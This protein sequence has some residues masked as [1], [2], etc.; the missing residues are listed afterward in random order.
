MWVYI[1]LDISATMTGYLSLRGGAKHSTKVLPLWWVRVWICGTHLKEESL[2]HY[3]LLN[4]IWPTLPQLPLLTYLWSS[5][6]C[7]TLPSQGYP[8]SIKKFP[9]LDYHD[10]LLDSIIVEFKIAMTI[11]FGW[12]FPCIF[13]MVLGIVLSLSCFSQLKSLRQRVGRR[14]FSGA[15]PRTCSRYYLFSISAGSQHYIDFTLSP[16]ASFA[17]VHYLPVLQ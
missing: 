10:I 8:V 12:Y 5:L 11:F 1:P 16:L 4:Y 3:N 15:H 17:V 7:H 6:T 2:C 9:F 13:F 14:K